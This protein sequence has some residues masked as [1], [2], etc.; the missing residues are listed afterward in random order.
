MYSA[1]LQRAGFL[2]RIVAVLAMPT[3]GFMSG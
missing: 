1:G 2:A 3:M